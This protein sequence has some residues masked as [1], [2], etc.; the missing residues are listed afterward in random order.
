MTEHSLIVDHRYANSQI[1]CRLLHCL[2]NTTQTL[3]M[4]AEKSGLSMQHLTSICLGKSGVSYMDMAKLVKALLGEQTELR[5]TLYWT[6][7]GFSYSESDPCPDDQE[8]TKLLE[9]LQQ[10]GVVPTKIWE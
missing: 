3:E 4:I 9:T 7:C 8:C 6:D 10:D 2:A 1:R 5:V